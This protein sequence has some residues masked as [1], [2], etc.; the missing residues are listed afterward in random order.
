MTDELRALSSI[1]RLDQGSLRVSS[2]AEEAVTGTHSSRS[3]SST[4]QSTSSPAAEASLSAST[5]NP[6][7]FS[8]SEASAERP[9][10]NA[11]LAAAHGCASFCT[12]SCLL[13]PELEHRR[14]AAMRQG[15]TTA[16]AWAPAHNAPASSSSCKPGKSRRQRSSHQGAHLEQQHRLHSLV[17][18]L[19]S[20]VSSAR[21]SLA[22]PGRPARLRSTGV[23]TAGQPVGVYTCDCEVQQPYY[24]L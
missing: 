7:S 8:M 3:L 18:A 20:P 14:A 1:E 11:G 24:K 21:A 10:Q 17:S 2:H 13:A 6:E 9:V 23:L 19:V 22:A 12:A 4:L 5:P 16:G 15:G